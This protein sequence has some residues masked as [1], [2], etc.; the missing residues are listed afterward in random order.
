M[1]C[2]VVL[3]VPIQNCL[4]KLWI[5]LDILI[6]A[7]G[8]GSAHRKPGTYTEQHNT[9]KRGHMSVPGAGF[10]PMIPVF[11]LSEIA[12]PLG[13][14]LS[15][16]DPT[17]FLRTLCSPFE[18]TGHVPHPS[19]GVPGKIHRAWLGYR[20]DNRDSIPG[21]GKVVNFLFV[22]AVPR[23]ALGPTLPPRQRVSHS[24]TPGVKRQEREANLSPP[25]SAGVKNEWSPIRLHGV[26]R[27]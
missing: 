24:L 26:V 16:S 15:C 3:F 22:T 18:M 21:K 13:S 7:L 27:S 17:V 10:E 19:R 8:W 23:P 2:S 12:R 6:G 25:S 11:E 1:L 14:V 20:L 9:Q 4:L 5:L